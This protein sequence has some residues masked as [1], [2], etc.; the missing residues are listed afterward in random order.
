MQRFTQL[1]NDLDG[2]TS[3]CDKLAAL[4]HYFRDVPAADAAWALSLLYG[5]KL[6]RVVTTR[7][8]RA[9]ATEA[10]GLPDWLFDEAHAHVGD[11]AETIS[12]L[13]PAVNGH[14]EFSLA[15]FIEQ[16][17]QALHGLPEDEQRARVLANWQ[18][19]DRDER[20]L[21]H[22]M[23][24]GSF[25]APVPQTLVARA[26]AQVAGV[27]PAV[28]ANR[29]A[30][31]WQPSAH[32]F[33]A[34]MSSAAAAGDVGQPHPFFFSHELQGN[35]SSLGDV[36]DWQI[37][38]MWDGVRAQVIQRSGQLLVWSRGEELL[39]D[40][41]PELHSLATRLPEGTVLDGAILA[42][43]GDEPASI[44]LL[45]KRLSRKRVDAKLLAEAPIAFMAYDVLETGGVDLRALPLAE[46]RLRLEELFHALPMTDSST[47]AHLSP[48]VAATAWSRVVELRQQARQRGAKGLM[49]K[50]R[51]SPYGTGRPHGA[52]WKWKVAPLSI[53]AVLMYAQAGSSGR[54]APFTEYTFGVWQGDQLVPIAKSHLELSDDELTEVNAFI[55]E[56]TI[57]KFG[58]VR[59]VEP[60]LVFELHFEGIQ[61]SSRHK[62]GVTLRLPRIVR[63]R[64]DKQ[65]IEADSLEMLN[66][67]LVT[68]DQIPGQASGGRKPPVS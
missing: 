18:L 25:R 66:R 7:Q 55:R 4:E 22:K 60:Q 29:L 48:L 5:R 43:R 35:V 21:W 26:L 14:C 46:R 1:I 27:N 10:T 39:T 23:L 32:F 59:V 40:R 58:P 2:H 37:E 56:H 49:L 54:A 64:K 30:K 20:Y 62:S 45:H 41:F 16:H 28:M 17:V 24:A 13:L 3:Q 47:P 9:W 52:W 34:L 51:D 50:R 33:T 44:A 11:L 15:Q 68:M 57:E 36:A 6:Q 67:M 31:T 65:P 19:L 38:W 42:W 61:P 53:N 8:L 12:A 63:W